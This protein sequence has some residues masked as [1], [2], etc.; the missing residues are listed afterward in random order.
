MVDRTTV[1]NNQ[2]LEELQLGYTIRSRLLRCA[3]V[4]V[5]RNAKRESNRT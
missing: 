5:A 4:R 3:M 1:K 2:V